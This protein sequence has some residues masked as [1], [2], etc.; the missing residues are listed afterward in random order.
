MDETLFETTDGHAVTAVTAEEM[1][2]VDRV[3]VEGVGLALGQ[4]MENAGR[5]LAAHGRELRS[6][7]GDVVVLAGD[8][9][10]GGGGMAC[11]RHLANR[12]VPVSVV[13][14][15]DPTDL[16]GAAAQQHAILAAMGVSVGVGHDAVPDDPGLV[17]DALVG[18]G[19]SGPLTGVAADLVTTTA[20]ADRTL[21]L[22]VPTGRNATSGDEPGVAVAPDRVLTLALP[23][24]GLGG[25]YWNLW[26]ADIAIPAT[27]Y[28][29]LDIPYSGP[30][31]EYWVKLVAA[32]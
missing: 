17:V 19:L 22:D 23:K 8:G 4:M 30:F 10:N 7:D 24:T 28:D 27:V 6:T 26:L 18:Y 25:G 29:R 31:E 14:D 13:L 3:A 11:A 12:D 9:G 20:D 32:D 16:S 2:A 1:R 15:R 5:N 21:S